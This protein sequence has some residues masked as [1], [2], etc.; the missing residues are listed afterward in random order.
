MTAIVRRSARVILLDGDELLLI[1]RTRPGGT[2]YW[3]TVGG[4]VE[5]EDRTVEA[6]AHREV[7]EELGA[8][9]T[10]PKLVFLI[11]DE[12][13]AGIGVQHIFVARLQSMNIRARTG[14]E[15]SKP[16]RGVYEA[17]RVPFTAE[18]LRSVE[19]MPPV[20]GEYVA[21]NITA[22]TEVASSSP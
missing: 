3:V 8:T 20:L 16:E 13:D 9:I 15:F 18:G 22:L 14:P 11:T 1:K 2:P 21:A 19:L 7:F 5:P 12:L 4:G 6:A 10:A 17:V